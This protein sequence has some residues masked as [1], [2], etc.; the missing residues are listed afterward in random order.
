MRISGEGIVKAWLADNMD[1]GRCATDTL[2]VIPSGPYNA[3]DMGGMFMRIEVVQQGK[4]AIEILMVVEHGCAIVDAGIDKTVGAV[5]D[6]VVPIPCLREIRVL[7]APVA[8]IGIDFPGP[9]QVCIVLGENIP[10]VQV[11]GARFLRFKHLHFEDGIWHS[12]FNTRS[13]LKRGDGI[14]HGG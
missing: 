3:C 6:K 2:A 5:T 8:S 9:V 7:K 1:K 4:I 10:G 11:D 12:D 13:L 14:F